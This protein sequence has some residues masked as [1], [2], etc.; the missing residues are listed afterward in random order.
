MSDYEYSDGEEEFVYSDGEQGGEQGEGGDDAGVEVSLANAFYEAEDLRRNDPARALELFKRVVELEKEANRND[1]AWRFKALE[2]I[3]GLHFR[4]GN[5]DAMVSAYQEL[6]GCLD[7]VTRNECNDT[8]NNVLDTISAGGGGGA[9]ATVSLGRMYEITLEVL[10]S[11]ANERLW[12]NTNLKLGKTYLEAADYEHLAGII[13]SL[14]RSL[15]MGASKDDPN[16]DASLLEVYALEIA[17]YSATRQKQKLKE[18]YPKTRSLSAAIQDPRIMGGI[19][20][21]GGKMKMEEEKWSDAYD[22]FFEAFRNY[23]DAGNPRAKQCLK[24]VVLANMIALREINPFDSREAKVYKDDKEIKGMMRLRQAFESSDVKEFEAVLHDRSL[25]ITDDAFLS[26][27]VDS[28]LRNIRSQ[29]LVRLV[30]PYQRVRTSYLA[31]EI[32]VSID[33]LESLLVQLI[34]DG[35]IAAKLDQRNAILDMDC[36]AR[37]DTTKYDAINTWLNRLGDIVYEY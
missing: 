7:K 11:N 25:G 6:L 23:Q 24:Y 15:K 2:H 4:L 32:N 33:D 34:L 21:E 16:K 30:R 8:I 31:H 14:H 22:D 3:V 20:E 1:V 12:F 10:K 9:G 18:I 19:Y 37:K 13:D 28:L 29:V 17:L 35:K 36:A 26:Q 5:A 27:Y